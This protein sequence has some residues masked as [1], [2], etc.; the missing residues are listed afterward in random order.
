MKG[1][2]VQVTVERGLEVA[3]ESM[4]S[5]QPT[6][7]CALLVLSGPLQLSPTLQPHGL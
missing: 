1:R 4:S 6:L 3:P 2:L 7:L 5:V